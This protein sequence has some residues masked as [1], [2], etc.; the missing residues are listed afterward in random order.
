MLSMLKELTYV[1]SIYD[2]NAALRGI[3]D[4]EDEDEESCRSHEGGQSDPLMNKFI[5]TR[6]IILSGEINKPLAEKVIRQLLV[7]ESD[8]D[9]PIRVFIDSPGGDADAG[10]AIFDMIRFV[11]A[12]VYTIG[13]GLVAS[14]G[15]II[16][17][18]APKERRFGLPNSHYLIHQP[19]SGIKGVATE[20]EIHAL[21]LEK[22]RVR[23]NELISAET[24]KK[25]DQVSKDTDRDF[26]MN[27][28]EAKD[29]GLVSKVIAS[30]KDLP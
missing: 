27:A 7:L 21:E 22:M 2:N 20:I 24:G 8:S 13:M 16:L 28:T 3:R 9:E 4:E 25:V 30:R 12:P 10:Y 6:Q 1:K 23:I 14:A 15:S 19:L 11:N 17:L 29:Y 5:K 18:A 26:W